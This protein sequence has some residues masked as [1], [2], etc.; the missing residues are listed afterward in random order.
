MGEPG[1]LRSMGLQ[2]VGHDWATSLSLFTFHALEKE[3]ATHSSVLTWRIPG[4]EEPGG[5]PF[6]GSHRVGHDWS[7][8]AVAAALGCM[9]LFKLGCCCCFRYTPRG[10][11]AK[12]YGSSVYSFL[13]NLHT[14]FHSGCN[15]LHSRQQFTRVPLLYV[16]INIC[17]L[18]F[19]FSTMIYYKILNTVS[20]A[21]PLALLR[22]DRIKKQELT[23][24][25]AWYVPYGA[26]TSCIYYHIQS[27]CDPTE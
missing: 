15:N 18:C 7:D 24:A 1:W 23:L 27:S 12:S 9:Y 5:L 14:V 8:L 26:R 25:D 20:C 17:Y 3:M 13:R 21:I 10:G 6:M 19:F 22:K 2:R 11:I 16:L 4:M